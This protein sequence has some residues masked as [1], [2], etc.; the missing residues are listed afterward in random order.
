MP[1]RYRYRNAGGLHQEERAL[2]SRAGADD[3]I[4]KEGRDPVPVSL[5][6]PIS[7]AHLPAAEATERGLGIG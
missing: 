6:L 7:H 2:V 3:Q 4:E 5:R 1:R